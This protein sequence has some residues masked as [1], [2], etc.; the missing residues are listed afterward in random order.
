MI[1]NGKIFIRLGA[2]SALITILIIV[3]GLAAY[4]IML[5]PPVQ[6]YVR[7]VAEEKLD[8][9]LEGN[10]NIGRIRSNL[11]SRVDMY[12]IKIRDKNGRD[13]TISLGH[14]RVK[15]NI[16]AVLNK[17]VHVTSVFGKDIFA[18]LSVTPE[19]DY[20][21]PAY[22]DSSLLK[23]RK[24]KPH[25][26]V[27]SREK[28]KVV[29]GVVRL[30]NFNAIYRDSCLHFTG[31]V[32]RASIRAKFPQ[33]D[34]IIL[35]LRV[36]QAYY[37][38]FW[39][40]GAL[41]TIGASAILKFNGLNILESYVKGSGTEVRGKG[42]IPFRKN[43]NWDLG[44]VVSTDVAPVNAIYGYAPAV[45]PKGHIW[46]EASWK[47]TLQNPVLKY[48]TTGSGLKYGYFDIDS[49]A[50]HGGYKGDSWASA[51][52]EIFTPMGK[53]I[54]DARLQIPHLMTD[55]SF[56]FYRGDIKIDQAKLVLLKEKLMV[57][58]KR[59]P[60]ENAIVE[61]HLKGYG[62]KR[63]P[64]Y[65]TLRIS[66][67]DNNFK[68]DTM[69][70]KAELHNRQWF[71][72][73]ELG[74]ALVTGNGRL[75]S[76]GSIYGEIDGQIGSLA[77]L[78]RYF[79]K[80][81]ISGDLKF[82]TSI[83]GLIQN[84][85]IQ[86][87]VN[88]TALRWRSVRVKALNAVADYDGKE[89]HIR[90]ASTSFSANIDT[91]AKYFKIDSTGGFIVAS[92]NA[93]GPVS[94]LDLSASLSGSRLFYKGFNADSVNGSIA[95]NSY[96]TINWKDLY[97][98]SE[99]TEV[100]TSG[101]FDLSGMRTDAGLE[102]QI[103]GEGSKRSA[104][105]VSVDGLVGP[106]SV[107][108]L[109]NVS[110]LDFAALSPWLKVDKNISGA[111]SAEGNFE[112][113]YNNLQGIIKARLNQP[114]FKRHRLASVDCR[115]GL[116]DSLLS[117]E[118]EIYLKDSSSMLHLNASL[119]LL[120][121]KGW[122]FDVE[123]V[124]KARASLS[125]KNI[126]L[127][128]IASIL[129]SGSVA[130]GLGNV[131]LQLYNQDGNWAIEGGIQVVNGYYH[132]KYQN[133]TINRFKFLSAFSGTVL[134][135]FAEYALST[136]AVIVNN[137]NADSLFIKGESTIDTAKITSS[138]FWFPRDGLME[139]SAKVPLKHI[140]S[141]MSR[142]GFETDFNIV[143][144]PLVLVSPFI[145]ENMI[146]SGEVN[147]KGSIQIT[148]GRPVLSG[149]IKLE[150]AKLAIEDIEPVIGPI[151]A[152]IVL[153][154]D[155][156]LLRQL[157]GKCGKGS[158]NGDGFILWSSSGLDEVRINVNSK[159]LY[160]DMRD[161]AT[162]R[163]QN[164]KLH[165]SN[166]RDGGYL[167]SG[168]V[169]LGDTRV[170][171][172]LKITDL[173]EQLQKNKVTVEA[174]SFLQS[175]SLMVEVNLLDNLT[176]DMNLGDLEM[177]GEISIAGT[178]AKPTYTGEIRINEGFVYYF[179][180]KFEITKGTFY[181]YNPYDLDPLID[182]E[183]VTEVDAVSA[184]TNGALETV[185][186]YT[187][188]LS[189]QGNLS[190]PEV[191]LWVDKVPMDEGNIISILTLGQPLGA[192]GGDLGSRLKSFA[193]QSIVGFGARKLEQLL[194]IER[195]DL[196]GNIFDLNSEEDSPTLSLTKRFS[197]RFLLSYETALG[198]L[199]KPKVT[200]MF[201]LTKHFFVEGQTDVDN[202]GL[203][204]L[205]KYSR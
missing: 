116:I 128:G 139:I 54:I 59:I 154:Q 177:G 149:S 70:L 153:Q 173:V 14:L 92:V 144:F 157:K 50:M 111:I 75:Q 38:S 121:S 125:G 178:A 199:T 51:A 23:L 138:S 101:E 151:S 130:N 150:N 95:S 12:D 127:D 170:I 118:S 85:F 107:R 165:F 94:S 52:G 145:A 33:I 180:R 19:K 174:D 6:N 10:V 110:R 168:S 32:T 4:G 159:D 160:L 163:I 196:K 37:G 96:K 152:Q 80:E 194:G 169:E 117:A 31:A 99:D 142:P 133:L 45:V 87:T 16:L 102:L 105:K 183:A 77:P 81:N 43:G 148:K 115:I 114:G 21:I 204:L 161:L 146:R 123:G 193:Q 166:K 89:I 55:P 197:P 88:S 22:P 18:S 113:K 2:F 67:E 137:N 15:F 82:K 112:G 44:A 74:T 62:F 129:D 30:R 187:I 198:N 9:L 162:I 97:I 108:A 83:N 203:D 186:S 1:K 155:S 188:Y 91:V 191:R 184:T 68:N 57:G 63:L 100:K 192:I 135:P 141:L 40:T 136:G 48:K 34:S 106:D 122:S 73:G 164:G 53:A 179:D 205:F 131:S 41:D 46:V 202:H 29:I 132:N 195:I 65:A 47:G 143:K 175:L 176:V 26:K 71:I 35:D 66:A 49:M 171:R 79:L 126:N 181:N 201:R 200:A 98:I 182:L 147:G 42:S 140:D 28:W 36:P 27:S 58:E 5:L 3:F 56:G 61:G 189:I 11:L 120:P 64:D 60:G 86:C 93:S 8:S 72:D 109:F 119:P 76:N 90:D 190:K 17:T 104:G 185:E 7:D 20:K 25:S 13:D 167:I 134:K 156:I 172:D 78:S 39:W 103:C 24:L 69:E 124:R 84:P 158:I